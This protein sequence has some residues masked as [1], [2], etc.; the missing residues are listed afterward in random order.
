MIY[1]VMLGVALVLMGPL[2]MIFFGGKARDR[3]EA[4]MELHRAQLA[5]L[6][7]DR[8]E[9]R[10]AEQEYAAARLEVERRLLAADLEQ[11]PA[12]DGNARLLLLITVVAVPLMAFAL[13]L[14][15]A[16]VEIP[17]EPHAQWVK[18]ETD[19]NAKLIGIIAALRMRLASE[20]PA[21]ADASQGESYLAEIL[22]E[23]A[24]R[25]TPEALSYFKQSLAHAPANANWRQL[26][27]TRIA[28]A[29]AQAQA[30]Q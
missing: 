3:R 21:S 10:I 18:R 13:Y 17:S 8:A 9:G 14:P 29:Q 23:Q 27:T 22:S 30:S 20:D 24:G 1:A 15:D 11:E 2:V 6:V 19:A 28:Q 7:R 12:L 5:E 4:A 26:D 25:I 16:A